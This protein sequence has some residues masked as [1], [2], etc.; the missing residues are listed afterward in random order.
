MSSSYHIAHYESIDKMQE[1]FWYKERSNLIKALCGHILTGKG[2]KRFLE[3]GCGT[4]SVLS[5]FEQLGFRVTGIDINAKALAYARRKTHGRLICTPFLSFQS[6][7]RFDVIGMF[8]VLEHQRD[9]MA[10]LKKCHTLLRP[11]GYLFISV[12]ACSWVWSSIDV[13]SG[14]KR[15]YDKDGLVEKLEK[16]GYTVR[17]IN[18]WNVLL[19][20]WYFLWRLQFLY[21]SGDSDV[22]RYV[23]TPPSCINA[24]CAALLSLERRVIFSMPFPVGSSLFLVAQKA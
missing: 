11:N 18:Y 3:V 6:A 19:F 23:A 15:R 13:I 8:D 5:V 17:F 2:R 16:A 7:L 24:L 9:D 12:P 1:H 4:G 21:T 22:N 20:G 14:H 10:F